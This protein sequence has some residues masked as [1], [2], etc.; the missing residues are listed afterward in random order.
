MKFTDEKV[1]KQSQR[2]LSKNLRTQKRKEK[3]NI[4]SKVLQVSANPLDL[5]AENRSKKA[6]S[7]PSYS[8]Y[9]WL[10]KNVVLVR[11]NLAILVWVTAKRKLLS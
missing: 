11:S 8:Y 1:K 7:N 10:L 3:L 5:L 2:N 6:R 4:Q 9:V